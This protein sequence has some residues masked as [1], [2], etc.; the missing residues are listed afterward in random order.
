M[1]VEVP[2][3]LNGL[4]KRADIVVYT[5]KMEPWMIVECKSSAVAL[6]QKVY[7]QAARYNLTLK[8]PYLLVTNGLK[9]FAAQVDFMEQKVS[10]LSAIPE[11]TF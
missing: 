1:G 10:R 2:L 5:R 6:D 11:Y 8:V 7:D 9:L 3:R 4:F